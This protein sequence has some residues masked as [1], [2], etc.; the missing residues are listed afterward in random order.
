MFYTNRILHNRDE[1]KL[2]E[3]KK[4]EFEISN[5]ERK[6]KNIIRSENGGL[7]ERKEKKK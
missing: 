4:L 1:K 2:E 6:G 7:W 5:K 3:L